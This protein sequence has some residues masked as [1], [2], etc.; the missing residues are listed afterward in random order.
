MESI[1][2]AEELEKKF[3]DSVLGI[4]KN[5]EMI[6][7]VVSQDNII[8]V[9]QFLKYDHKM[10]YL[11]CL[12]G[13]DNRIRNGKFIERFEVIYEIYSIEG[14]T[15]I[16]LRAQIM[17]SAHPIIDS[18]TSLWTEAGWMEREAYDFA[19]IMFKNHHSFKGRYDSDLYAIKQKYEPNRHSVNR[20]VIHT[21]DNNN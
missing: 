11:N 14:G 12:C 1:H 15:F 16:Q 18:I 20:S 19:G 17:E 3:P 9:C 5:R 8:A 10:S 7:I 2:I 13:V 6:S 4:Q 21:L